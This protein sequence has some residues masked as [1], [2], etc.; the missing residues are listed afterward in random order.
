MCSL[1]NIVMNN[2]TY[3]ITGSK[4][5]AITKNGSWFQKK[6]GQRQRNSRTFHAWDFVFHSSK[7]KALLNIT[8][9]LCSKKDHSLIQEHNT[10][11][12]TTFSRLHISLRTFDALEGWTHEAS[13]R[14]VKDAFMRKV[15]WHEI[16]AFCQEILAFAVM[17]TVPS[18]P[19]HHSHDPG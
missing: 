15:H 16:L 9:N 7:K 11:F 19:L 12:D 13:T 18:S 3:R 6:K 10:L 4:Y 14:D 8:Q 1:A 17:K 2:F 5:C